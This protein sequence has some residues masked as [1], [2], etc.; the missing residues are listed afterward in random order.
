[1]PM[2]RTPAH[3]AAAL[4]RVHRPVKPR[5]LL[6]WA[7]RGLLPRLAERGRGQAKGKIYYWAERDIVHQAFIVYELL[8]WR[9]RTDEVQLMLWLL[10]YKVSVEHWIRP[11]FLQMFEGVEELPEEGSL[12]EDGKL[13]DRGGHAADDPLGPADVEAE[14]ERLMQLSEVAVRNSKRWRHIPRREPNHRVIAD[15]QVIEIYLNV[16]LNPRYEPSPEVLDELAGTYLQEIP[17]ATAHRAPVMR[18][19]GQRTPLSR[20]SG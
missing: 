9:H 13:L 14:E 20:G 3:V 12:G 18:R 8:R 7:E 15:P 11:S 17:K 6:S 5:T 4:N 16:L 10:G 19:T 1:M 2:Y